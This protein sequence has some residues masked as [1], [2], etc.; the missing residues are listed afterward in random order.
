MKPSPVINV[1]NTVPNAPAKPAGGS[2]SDQSFGQVLAQQVNGTPASSSPS[3]S[4]SANGNN[5]NSAPSSTGPA[6]SSGSSTGTGGSTTAPGGKTVKSKHEQDTGTASGTAQAGSDTNAAN[7]SA[8]LLALVSSVQQ[9]APGASANTASGNAADGAGNAVGAL[10]ANAAAGAQ[11][12]LANFQ[13]AVANGVATG[14]AVAADA[15]ATA[16]GF[17]QDIK[18]ALPQA[19]AQDTQ[20]L[21]T[22]GGQSN[23][24]S[25]KTEDQ[26]ASSLNV[27]G[28]TAATP[29]T[30]ADLA[31]N[32]QKNLQADIANLDQ[33]AAKS[34]DAIR[35]TIATATAAPAMVGNAQISNV[36][37]QLS[38]AGDKLTPQ[39]G[40]PGWDQALGQKVV[41]MV[42][43]GQ[44]SASLTL[45]PPDLGP[46]QVVLNVTN[47]HAT[48]TFTAAQPEVRQ[49][50]ETA[51]PKL[52]E[53]LGDA[54]I[55]LGQ[56]SV[57][58]GNA[59]QQQ[60]FA[61]QA[62]QNSSGRH[63]DRIDAIDGTGAIATQSTT[64]TTAGI[65]LVD[66]F[67]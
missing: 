15:A 28:Q 37:S 57:N 40:T 4:S 42:A 34:A 8:Q 60:N 59:Q 66:T 13:A 61:G 5:Q 62:S 65:G 23:V 22:D 63:G 32:A 33:A 46:M 29:Q 1:A 45:N 17:A 64:R 51:M 67:A 27:D 58:A 2:S 3:S 53:M 50:L 43:G 7:G 41:W 35:N 31:A 39:V 44:Q 14:N 47:S 56:T 12:A 19:T 10:A 38:G 18:N 9:T 25:T 6:N 21:T 54:G 26:A 16:T 48:A 11:A 55:Q 24:A 36:A 52:R 49:A 30:V 20:N